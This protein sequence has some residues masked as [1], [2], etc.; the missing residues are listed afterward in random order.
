MY[1][2]RSCWTEFNNSIKIHKNNTVCPIFVT[3][4]AIE[5]G[6]KIRKLNSINIFK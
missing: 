6:I 4:F 1:M 5:K 3:Q 2:Y